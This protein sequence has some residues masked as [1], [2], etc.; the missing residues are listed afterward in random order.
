M[1]RITRSSLKSLKVKTARMV[2]KVKKVYPPD[3]RMKNFLEEGLTEGE[4]K[5]MKL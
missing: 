5:L 2:K 3:K 4:R 1:T